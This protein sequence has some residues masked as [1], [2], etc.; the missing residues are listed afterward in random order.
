MLETEHLETLR[1][2]H[3]YACD[4]SYLCRPKS[5][6]SRLGTFGHRHVPRSKLFFD[7]RAE[8]NKEILG[9]SAGII[10]VIKRFGDINA[11]LV[12][13]VRTAVERERDDRVEAVVF[14]KKRTRV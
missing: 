2:A 13:G 10:A 11:L 6:H 1:I 14:S 8:V 5:S 3:Q 12:S 9:A 7:K 4:D